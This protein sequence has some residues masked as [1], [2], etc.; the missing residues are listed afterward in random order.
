MLGHRQLTMEDYMGI[1]RRRAWLLVVPPIVV[2]VSAYLVSRMIPNRYTSQTQVL[3][4]AQRVSTNIVQPI[5]TDEPNDRLASMKEQILSR[6]RLQPI[7]ERL[8]L[9]NDSNLAM[10]ARVQNLR[11]AI[12]VD[13]MRPME[14]TAAS[15]LPG[16]R[17]AVTMNN[18][19]LAQQVCTEVTSL[20]LE[21][22][23]KGR[24]TQ[25]EGTI[26]FLDKAL[27]DARNKMNEQDAKLAEF[28]GRY[29]GSLPEDGPQSLG[30][31]GS[32]STQLDAVTRGLDSDIQSK[33]FT[34]SVLEQQISAWKATLSPPTGLNPDT[35][36]EQLKKAQDDLLKLRAQY[37]D[38][39]PDVKS[40]VLE[41]DQLKQKIAAAQANKPVINPPDK[42]V[43]TT[44]NGP[45]AE[46]G[47]IKQLRATLNSL[48][49]SIRDKTKQQQELRN[50]LST[51]EAHLQLSPVVEQQYR[52][53]TRDFATAQEEYNTLLKQS[54]TASRGAELDRRQ[55]GEQF[56]ILDV[57]SLPGKPDFPPRLTITAGGFAGG[58]ALGLAVIILLEMRDK[59]IRT[60]G[61]VELFLK[62]PTLA[63]VPIIDTGSASKKRFVFQN[64]NEASLEART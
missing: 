63:L 18:A 7:V 21:E 38:S 28:K 14:A 61:D 41:I 56:R 44:S 51:Y 39:W 33:A 59:S 3:V 34:Q 36:Q 46:P 50:R 32:L 52:A 57:A 43:D 20:F 40:K 58:L 55:Q 12:Q 5:I 15:Q 1:L 11:D 4:Q 24:E 25:A 45:L 30:M 47:E 31:I 26:T 13:P 2:C 37:T 53:L 22:D 23:R 17:I 19:H 8:N 49:I 62:I 48:D 9:F 29:S 27:E 42:Q 64:K 35:L 6:S 60:E 10:D 54:G 16:F